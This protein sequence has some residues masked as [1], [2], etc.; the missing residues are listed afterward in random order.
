MIDEGRC[1]SDFALEAKIISEADDKAK[2][3]RIAACAANSRMCSGCVSRVP[4]A[5][6]LLVGC[7]HKAYVRRH[8]K[9]A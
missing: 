8:C 1:D 4:V 3:A 7:H 5:H 6:C 9:V 2:G